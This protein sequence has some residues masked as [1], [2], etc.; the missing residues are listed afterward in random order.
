MDNNGLFK[1]LD[2]TDSTNNYAMA[3]VRE[4]MSMHG[5]TWFAMEQTAGRG[6]RGKIWLSKPGENIL[7]SIAL[8]PKPQFSVFPFVYSALIA[9]T[10]KETLTNITGEPFFL[11]WPN[12]IYYND[13]K[14]G[15]ILIEN[16]YNGPEWKWA[17][18]GI[19]IN[20]NQYEFQS[21]LPNPTSLKL[22]AKKAFN[23]VEIAKTL[24]ENILAAVVMP[25]SFDETMVKYNEALYKKGQNVRLKKGNA[26]F[27][28][29][30]DS[31]N[32]AGQLITTGNISH[33]YNFGE[34]EWQV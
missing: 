8:E 13:N 33:Q 26:V 17:V 1:V 16:I 22:I 15:G 32:K 9:L 18:V 4:G 28:A 6:Q 11:K 34:V 29:T 21:S 24:Q 25:C 10:I 30:I 19:G 3:S 20:V 12:D 2:F 23:P 5:M 27:E 14:A 7:M 31:V